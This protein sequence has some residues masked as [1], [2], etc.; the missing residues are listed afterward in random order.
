VEILLTSIACA[1]GI[2]MKNRRDRLVL[3]KKYS[4]IFLYIPVASAF[5]K[6]ISVPV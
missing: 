5:I 3:C 2:I 4:I 1:G 6:L